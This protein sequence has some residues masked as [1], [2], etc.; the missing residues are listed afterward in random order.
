MASPTIAVVNFATTVSDDEARRAIHAVNR[1][2][3]EHFF[4]IWGS[5]RKLTLFAASFDPADAETLAEQKVPADSVLYLVDEGSVKGALG[6]HD[7]NTR[8]VPFGFVFVLNP[9]NWTTV[10]SHESLELILDPTASA[11]VPGPDP[12]NRKKTVLH[13]YE[14]CDAVE[15][16]SYSIGDVRVSDFVTPSYFTPGEARG[17]RND[18]LGVGVPSFGVT[19]GAHISFYDL[20]SGKFEKYTGKEPPPKRSLAKRAEQHDHAKAERPSDEKL[21]EVLASY[22]SQRGVKRASGLP[23]VHGLTRTARY[24]HAASRLGSTGATA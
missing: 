13:V 18:F 7:L 16:L 17:K 8:D 21:G 22:R 12:R 2:I 6:F 4:P 5:R 10:L 11:L 1:Q 23:E 24:R 14:A 3:T 20:E 19:R 15:R 9:A